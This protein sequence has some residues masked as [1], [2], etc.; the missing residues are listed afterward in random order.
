MNSRFSINGYNIAKVG[1]KCLIMCISAIL[2]MASWV[3]T[4]YSQT[5][6][7][8]LLLFKNHMHY[9]IFSSTSVVIWHF[10][11]LINN[12]YSIKQLLT[13]FHEPFLCM[14]TYILYSKSQDRYVRGWWEERCLDFVCLAILSTPLL[15]W[16]RMAKVRQAVNV[17]RD[18]WVHNMVYLFTL[19]GIE[20]KRVETKD[21]KYLSIESRRWIHG[22]PQWSVRD[23]STISSKYAYGKLFLRSQIC[24]LVHVFP[25]SFW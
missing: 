18:F 16:S 20:K 22:S 12:I 1:E 11:N 6:L 15:E 19:V 25:C 14:S 23:M 13:I 7:S 3:G 24:G 17:T 5:N 21:G 10:I 9:S 8:T 4:W 2:G